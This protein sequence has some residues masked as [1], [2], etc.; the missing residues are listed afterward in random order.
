M[1]EPA[2]IRASDAERDEVLDRLGRA[3]V[4][5]RL[6]HD[7]FTDRTAAALAARTVGDLTALTVDLPPP[8][9]PRPA[10]GP[11]VPGRPP[12]AVMTTVPG[13]PA[14]L[15]WALVGWAA[16][17][18]V[19]GGLWILTGAGGDHSGPGPRWLV[20]LALVIISLRCAQTWRRRRVAR[21][22]R[23]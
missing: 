11:A 3:H 23:H 20:M 19:S 18:A 14:L 4:E 10:A 8:M 13:W 21:P 17:F 16:V 7:E 9:P 15:G 6:D 12:G 22:G 1:V 5:G 2:L